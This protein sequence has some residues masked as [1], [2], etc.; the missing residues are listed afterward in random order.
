MLTRNEISIKGTASTL[1]AI[2]SAIHPAS[3]GADIGNFHRLSS[4][5]SCFVDLLFPGEDLSEFDFEWAYIESCQISE[6]SVSM[7]CYSWN[8]SLM[9]WTLRIGGL[10]KDSDPMFDIEFMAEK[11]VRMKNYGEDVSSPADVV[12][13]TASEAPKKI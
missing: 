6:E 2:Y 9:G 5:K 13:I 1:S 10:Y 7:A 8:G 12:Y 4:D 3:I 11:G